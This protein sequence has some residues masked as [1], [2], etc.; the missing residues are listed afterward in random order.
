MRTK[1]AIAL[2]IAVCVSATS[3]AAHAD[4]KLFLETSLGG[5]VARIDGSSRGLFDFGAHATLLLGPQ[6]TAYT[7]HA[8]PHVSVH[9]HGAH[10]TA[11]EA[12]GALL[13][14][15]SKEWG[16]TAEG[17]PAWVSLSDVD[18]R[19]GG[20]GRAAFGYV[21]DDRGTFALSARAFVEAR[22]YRDGREVIAGVSFNPLL[23]IA[24]PIA[25]IV[26]SEGGV[27]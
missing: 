24:V 5:G 6:A 17:G 21:G 16:V 27:R 15:T 13:F 8:G 18:T 22:A 9:T 23:L 14:K 26:A 11:I 2:S 3:S 10:G 1:D 19:F 20:F 12:G 7:L 25:L 4:A